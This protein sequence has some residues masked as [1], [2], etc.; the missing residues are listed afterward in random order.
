MAYLR[1]LGARSVPVVSRGKDFIYAQDLNHVARFVELDEDVQPTLPP[2]M[3][4]DRLKKFLDIA[5][6]CVNQIPT[7]KLGDQLPGRPR[8][9]LSLANHIFEIAG[10]FVKV[11]RGADFTGD[12]AAATPNSDRSVVELSS[13]QQQLINDIDTWWKDCD[14]ET[15]ERV[16][17][18]YY[19]NQT[20]HALL[21][22][23]AWHSAQHVRQVIMMLNNLGITPIISLTPDDLDDLPLPEKVWD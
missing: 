9:L 21:E 16:V 23:C 14:D 2:D 19:G 8:S 5:I 15:C 6:S 11:T 22:R 13:Y 18:T 3:L 20:L 17:T 12:V 1:S 4:V 10:G 7:E